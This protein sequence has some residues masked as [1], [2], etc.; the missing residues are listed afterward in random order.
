MQAKVGPILPAPEFDAT[1]AW[2]QGARVEFT[3]PTAA[4][5]NEP[6]TAREAPCTT[7]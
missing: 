3:S 5:W 4:P 6:S 1:Y 2:K 7:H